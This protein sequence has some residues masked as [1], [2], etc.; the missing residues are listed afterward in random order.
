MLKGYNVDAERFY[1][2]YSAKGWLMGNSPIQNWQYLVDDWGRRE[3]I[4]NRL[5]EQPQ[6]QQRQSNYKFGQDDISDDDI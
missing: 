4:T 6:I 2:Y 3:S 5:K 1:N